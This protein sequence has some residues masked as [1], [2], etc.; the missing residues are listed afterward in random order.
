[1][2]AVTITVPLLAGEELEVG[3]RLPT[4]DPTLFWEVVAVDA[5]RRLVTLKPVRPD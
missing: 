2:G 3:A 4:A 5:G 1:M